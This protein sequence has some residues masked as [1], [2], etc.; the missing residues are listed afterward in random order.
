MTR[1]IVSV[2]KS[3][4]VITGNPSWQQKTSPI[5]HLEQQGAQHESK[6]SKE[7]VPRGSGNA[8]RVDLSVDGLSGKVCNLGACLVA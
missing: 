5:I 8:L 3:L 2:A 4:L 6:E 7:P 1:R